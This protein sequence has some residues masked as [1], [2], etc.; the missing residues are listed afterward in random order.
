MVCRYVYESK[1]NSLL[2]SFFFI[3]LLHGRGKGS[4]VLGNCSFALGG[5]SAPSPLAK[6]RPTAKLSLPRGTGA[7]V[8]R[9]AWPSPTYGSRLRVSVTTARKASPT[10]LYTLYLRVQGTHHTLYCNYLPGDLF[11]HLTASRSHCSER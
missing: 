2:Y 3:H 10:C 7:A 6:R 5:C 4:R 9:S 1:L 11:V 8:A